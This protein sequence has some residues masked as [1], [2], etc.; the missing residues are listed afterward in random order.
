MLDSVGKDGV[1]GDCVDQFA[2][3]GGTASEDLPFR[4][5]PDELVVRAGK[6]DQTG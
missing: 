4:T 2:G 1:M 5:D 6:D 3:E